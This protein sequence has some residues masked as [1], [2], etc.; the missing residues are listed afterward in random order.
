[1]V[2]LRVAIR[3]I[4]L[5]WDRLDE[6]AR[7]QNDRFGDYLG[8]VEGHEVVEPMKS[9]DKNSTHALPDI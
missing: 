5:V 1:M 7:V 9:T 4:E 3:S 8:S 2:P 6:S